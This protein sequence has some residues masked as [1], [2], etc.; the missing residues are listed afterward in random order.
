MESEFHEKMI[1]VIFFY[2]LAEFLKAYAKHQFLVNKSRTKFH[3]I[4]CAL[5]F[6]VY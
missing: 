3:I 2:R 6:W 1:V 5:W 4:I